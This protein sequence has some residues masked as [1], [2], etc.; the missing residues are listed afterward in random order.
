MDN[1]SDTV[2]VSIRNIERSVDR[3]GIASLSGSM[4]STPPAYATVDITCETADS[5]SLVG[6]VTLDSERRLTQ[7]MPVTCTPPQASTPR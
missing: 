2:T 6:S 7:T 5:T 4:L 3:P 1:T